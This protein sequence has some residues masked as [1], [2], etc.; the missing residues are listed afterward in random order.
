MDTGRAYGYIEIP[1][2]PQDNFHVAVPYDGKNRWYLT[3][4]AARHYLEW[5]AM[6]EEAEELVILEQQFRATEAPKA[7]GVAV[8]AG[9]APIESAPRPS[10][11]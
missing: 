11:E 9:P 6:Q 1:L 8:V 3:L 10:A 2:R 5:L 7:S 4:D